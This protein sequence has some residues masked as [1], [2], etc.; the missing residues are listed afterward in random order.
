MVFPA[1]VELENRTNR[2]FLWASFWSII[3]YS[4]ALVATGF[5]A[6]YM[7]G[8]QVRP[9]LLDNISTK[10]GSV[11]VMVRTIYCFVLLFHLPYI[12]YTTKE[13]TLVLYDEITTKSLSI[14]LNDKL[15]EFLDDKS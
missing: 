11:S 8:S 7:F 1:Y 4:T 5:I 10:A 6:V 12:F 15:K 13:Y 14:H 3:I 2:R 9:D